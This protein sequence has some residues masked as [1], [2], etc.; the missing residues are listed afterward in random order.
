MTER[1]NSL[2]VNR[3]YY[4]SNFFV[5]R[6]DSAIRVNRFQL[7]FNGNTKILPDF[8]KID[9]FPALTFN[10]EPLQNIERKFKDQTMDIIAICEHYE[11]MEPVTL[12][13]KMPGKKR[14][15]FLVDQTGKV[16][17]CDI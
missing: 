11:M 2:Q 12:G 7:I 6:S 17:Q 15:I 9:I 10:F 4:F 1:I 5:K 14:E 16:L 8:G 13:N 3:I